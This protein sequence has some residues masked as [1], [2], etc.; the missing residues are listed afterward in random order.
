M[1]RQ[2]L[3][4]AFLIGIVGIT[5]AT[6]FA[7]TGPREYRTGPVKGRMIDAGFLQGD[8]NYNAIIRASDGNVYYVLCSHN[9]ESNACLFRY[10]PKTGEVKLVGN[11][12]DVLGEDRKQVFSQ[13]KVHCD[14]FEYK[15]KLWFG[16]HCGSYE[17]GGSKERGPYPGGHFMTYDLA[18][19]KFEDLGIAIPEQGLL[20]V[21]MDTRRERLYAVT[22]PDLIFLYY[23]IPTRKVKSFGTA[24][25]TMGAKDLMTVLGPRSLGID[26]RTGNVYWDSPDNTIRCYDYRKDALI[27][28]ETPK[29]DRELVSMEAPEAEGTFWRAIRWSESLQK[30]YGVT[31]KGE[32]LFSFD[33]QSGELEFIDRITCGPSWK[34]GNLSHPNLS[35]ELSA[36]GRT[37]YYISGEALAESG[38]TQSYYDIKE[39]IHLVTY[40]IPSGKY[41]DHGLV[42][43][44][45]G[46]YPSYCQSLEVGRDGNLYLVSFI[47]YPD[48]DS[49]KG[50]KII[51]YRFKDRPGESLIHSVTE[52][53]LI[54]VPDPLFKTGVKKGK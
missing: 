27:T 23:D 3:A 34:A 2:F 54:V 17:R 43:L 33:P 8:S 50:R 35:F 11:L 38:D 47:P 16:T 9:L 41:I 12:N 14:F 21:S 6:G 15:G 20:S 51:E 29:L 46:R 10:T 44:A 36:D 49:E 24:V 7:D 37:V 40:S 32:Y 25:A 5:V 39:K 31:Y 4:G 52:V 19:G 1:K 42:E 26:P 13:G 30:F 48:F 45:D 18:A 28:L 53:N 22:W